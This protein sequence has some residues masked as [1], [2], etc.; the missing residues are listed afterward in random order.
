MIKK[1]TPIQKE[2]VDRLE[3]QLDNAARKGDV[4]GQKKL[5]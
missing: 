4:I 5:F 3:S 1:I 2:R